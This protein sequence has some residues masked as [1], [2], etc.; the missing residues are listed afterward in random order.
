VEFRDITNILP[1]K[2]GIFAFLFGYGSIILE[3]S[4]DQSLMRHDHIRKHEK[5]A[6][7][8][9]EKCYADKRKYPQRESE[10]S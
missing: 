10:V 7:E 9:H 3:T 1:S 4:S 8:I 2:E 6:Q 5:I